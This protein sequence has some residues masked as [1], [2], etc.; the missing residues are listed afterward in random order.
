MLTLIL[1]SL[2]LQAPPAS[3]PPSPAQSPPAVA[4]SP[5]T[6]PSTQ[7]GH[8]TVGDEAAIKAAITSDKDVTITGV[9]DTAEWSKSGKVFKLTFVNG[10][11]GFQ[12][13]IFKADAPSFEKDYHEFVK[14]F[15]NKR[16][17]IK[18]KIVDYKGSAEV[19][20]KSS[21]QILKVEDK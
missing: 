11:V 2:A 18:G 3:P 8:I 19:V 1:L 6:A 20:L 13:V 5:T 14:A 7:P 4:T 17:T 16:L 12:A 9:V 15:A 10:Q 21:Q